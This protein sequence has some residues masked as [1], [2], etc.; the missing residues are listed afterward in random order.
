VKVSCTVLNG[1]DE[2]TYR[3]TQRTRKAVH[4]A[5]CGVEEAT[6][7]VPTHQT[8]GRIER[9][10]DSNMR[11][12]RRSKV[13]AAKMRYSQPDWTAGCGESYLCDVSP[14][15]EWRNPLSFTWKERSPWG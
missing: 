3:M 9:A 12:E 5:F 2:E 15:M 1:G 13:E 11:S 4:R 8:S 7:L 6:R 10:T 14:M